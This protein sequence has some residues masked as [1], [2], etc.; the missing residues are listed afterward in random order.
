[1]RR[2]Y[3]FWAIM[4][5]ACF[6]VV[7]YP[8]VD[9]GGNIDQGSSGSWTL[10]ASNT[11]NDLNGIWGSSGNWFAVGASGTILESTDDGLTWTK[12]TGLPA[13]AALE[14]VWGLDTGERFAAGG[15]NLL[16]RSISGSTWIA[17]QVPPA[18][19]LHFIWGGKTPAT[20]YLFAVG[21]SGLVLS[22]T[23]KGITWET[24]TTNA[25]LANLYGFWGTGL[26][27]LWAPGA[28][29]TIIHGTNWG[30]AWQAQQSTTQ[31]TMYAVWGASAN[32]I[33]AVGEQGTVLETTNLG[34][35]WIYQASATTQDLFGL[36]V[37]PAGEGYA[38]GHMGTIIHKQ[39]GGGWRIESSNT[40]A[41]LNGVF[42]DASSERVI[43][44]GARGTI[45]RR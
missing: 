31:L 43:I 6:E 16:K 17:S 34:T 35:T 8:I 10:V 19:P 5:S 14:G 27:D 37:S 7:P 44:V 24:I 23:D 42:G 29:G 9:G 39:A 26:G 32:D 36:W 11:S 30:T 33:W 3:L 2:G 1:M 45:L 18:Q 12:L 20:N 40:S 28:F 13:G 21:D 41:A 15:A 22:S 38:V 25:T 4:L